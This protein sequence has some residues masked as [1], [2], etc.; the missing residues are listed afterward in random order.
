MSGTN[1]Y[2]MEWVH[3][4]KEDYE[5]AIT[6]IRKRKRPTPNVVC[7]HSQQCAEKYLKAFL[8]QQK[9]VFPK[10]RDLRE[11]RRLALTTD[12]SFDLITDLLLHP[13]PYA[14]EFRYPGEEA[15]VEEAREAVTT[16]KT[17]RRFVRDKL[18]LPE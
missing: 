18:G 5:T 4:A 11:L 9:V 15:T 8:V 16:V 2:L 17:V 3:K 6:L 13:S 1:K 7:F 14:V 12:P 10:T